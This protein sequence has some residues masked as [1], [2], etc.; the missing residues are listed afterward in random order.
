MY[1]NKDSWEWHHR[2]KR[3]VPCETNHATPETLYHGLGY[4]L[5]MIRNIRRGLITLYAGVA[6]GV[7][8]FST[9]LVLGVSLYFNLYHNHPPNVVLQLT[10]PN[11]QRPIQQRWQIAQSLSG[12]NRTTMSVLNRVHFDTTTFQCGPITAPGFSFWT[13]RPS[14]IVTSTVQRWAMHSSYQLDQQPCTR[15]S[16]FTSIFIKRLYHYYGRSSCSH[17]SSY[18]IC[19]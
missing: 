5:N 15:T 9:D 2:K 18:T 19:G 1:Q 12:F 13:A 3:S 16:L 7:S 4:Q 11:Q 8:S 17:D 6:H 10:S 14:A